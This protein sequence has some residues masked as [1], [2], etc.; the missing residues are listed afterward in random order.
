MTSD[1]VQDNG[2][3]QMIFPAMRKKAEG[4]IGDKP[5]H[6]FRAMK[7]SSWYCHG[8]CPMCLHSSKFIIQYK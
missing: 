2:N 1:K 7:L 6:C 4:K 5:Q 3:N 8:G